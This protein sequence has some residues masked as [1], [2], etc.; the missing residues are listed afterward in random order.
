MSIT[1][2]VC[3]DDINSTNMIENL[4]YK[5]AKEKDIDIY[6]DVF[7]DGAML[8]NYMERSNK[9]YNL[10]YLDI[11]MDSLSGIETARQIRAKDSCAVV[12]FVSNYDSYFRD[13]LEVEPFRFL[14][15]PIDS[16]KFENYFL[17]ALEKIEC[18]NESFVFK[19]QKEMYMVKYKDIKYF[20][21]DKRII[22]IRGKDRS[23]Q[24]YGKLNEIEKIVLEKDKHFMRIHQSYL[25]NMQYVRKI[26]F[27]YMEM[28][29]GTIL[30]IS[31]DRQ[32]SFRYKYCDLIGEDLL[33]N[34]K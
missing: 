7:Y 1:I 26:T 5:I 6:I 12:I 21:S 11:E 14:D 15:K 17:K 20:E 30:N 23:Y 31:E 27:S 28:E 16:V 32:K 18:G 29:D 33:N 25:V 10:I 34:D 13:M 9:I 19:Y 24:F 22:H 2:A 8:I 3:D 4:L